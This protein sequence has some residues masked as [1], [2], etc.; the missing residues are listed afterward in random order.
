LSTRKKSSTT[1]VLNDCGTSQRTVREPAPAEIERVAHLFRN[2]I[3]RR[4]ARLLVATRSRPIE[5]F[6]AAVAW[7]PEG[8]VARFQFVCQPG[9]ARAEVGGLLLSSMAA[10]ARSAGCQTLEN[11][12]LLADDNEWLTILQGHG[13]E[14]VRSERAFQVA[15][16]DAW[17]RVMQLRQKYREQIPPSWRTEPIRHFAPETVLELVAPHRLMPPADI[18][19]H[20][21]ANSPAGFDLDL[22]CILFD[23][24]RPFGAFLLRR[25]ADLLYIDVQVVQETNPRLRSLG[26]LCLLYH[27]AQRVNPDGP[28]HRIQF[29]SGET[30]HRQTA[31][32]A[33]R[34]GGREISRCHVFA[35]T[36]TT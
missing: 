28:I 4:E 29:R 13:F 31:N 14:R 8:T 35:K 33:L 9:V 34:M 11:A 5:R 19:G 3:L 15:Y 6:V 24:A 20:W 2:V 21:R 36:L 25:M 17:S 1:P 22:S 23:G 7:W 18:C 10:A 16:R 30:E 26:D 27:D 32:L 12:G